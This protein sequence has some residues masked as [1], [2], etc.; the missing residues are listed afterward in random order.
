MLYIFFESYAH[1]PM[2]V[3]K[4]TENRKENFNSCLVYLK[5]FPQEQN[6]FLIPYFW[7][8]ME[9]ENKNLPLVLST[10]CMHK[11]SKF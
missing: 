6:S 1:K 5:Y 10:Y 3:V 2:F 11:F 8:K 9:H 4:K 7:I